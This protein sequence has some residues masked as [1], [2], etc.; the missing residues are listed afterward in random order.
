MH[1]KITITIKTMVRKYMFFNYIKNLPT[2][3]YYICILS[4]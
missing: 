1:Q 3:V 2:Y 4:C